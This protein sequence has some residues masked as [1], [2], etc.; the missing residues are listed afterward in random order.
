[1][2]WTSA[3]PSPM[4]FPREWPAHSG[5]KTLLHYSRGPDQNL[6]HTCYILHSYMIPAPSPPSWSTSPPLV[7]SLTN[8]SSYSSCSSALDDLI[9]T[10]S[11]V[12]MNANIEEETAQMKKLS[13][14]SCHNQDKR[15]QRY[16]TRKKYP[17]PLPLLARTGNLPGHM[18]WILT[19]HYIDG[20]L[21][22]VEERVKNREYFEAQ[23]ENGR[24]VLNIVPL[25]D[26]ITCSHFVS[27]NEEEKELQDVDFLGKNSD[28]E[29][30]EEEEEEGREAYQEIEQ[31][32]SDDYVGNLE[33]RVAVDDEVTNEK[34]VT[35]SA[36]LPK[37]SLKNGSKKSGD[38]R[39]CSTYAG[40]MI[41]DINLPCNAN[42]HRNAGECM[43]N[44]HDHPGKEE[45]G[46]M[47]L[48][49]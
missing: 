34:T 20:R 7:R 42:A 29:F 8:S 23:R 11:G 35:A 6:T 2:I 40:R 4:R 38:L 16:A 3:S 43:N 17:P 36:S 44:I 39:K 33:D 22:L 18:P 25:D 13:L 46:L 9:G 47:Y 48:V 21:V 28:Q 37:S 14:E 49:H 1:M 30:D 12:Y 15:K 5:L 10:E 26:K 27:K 41:S 24:L 45:M 31:L 19:R 32:A